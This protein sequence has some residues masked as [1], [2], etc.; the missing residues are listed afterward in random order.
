MMLKNTIA[1]HILLEIFSGYHNFK[2]KT[3]KAS[4]KYPWHLLQR[5]VLIWVTFFASGLSETIRPSTALDIGDRLNAT[6]EQTSYQFTVQAGGGLA[7]CILSGLLADRP[8]MDR[9]MSRK[10]SSIN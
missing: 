1:S 4:E 5:T 6:M 10:N 8:P 2:D 7:G 9:Q 3:K